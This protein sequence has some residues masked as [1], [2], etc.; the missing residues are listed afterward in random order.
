[1]ASSRATTAAA[2][3]PRRRRTR[4]ALDVRLLVR[5]AVSASVRSSATKFGYEVR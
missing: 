1:M 4:E 2:V 3:Q 5:S